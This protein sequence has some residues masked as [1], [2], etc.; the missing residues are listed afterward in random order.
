MA[1]GKRPA[2]FRTWKLSPA[3]PMVL[4]PMGCG[5]V[6]HR[7]NTLTEAARDFYSLW[8]LLCALNAISAC[9]MLSFLMSLSTALLPD[10][11]PG[12]EPTQGSRPDPHHQP[13][14]APPIKPNLHRRWLP[15]RTPPQPLCVPQTLPC[16][17][18]RTRWSS[19]PIGPCWAG[20]ASLWRVSAAGSSMHAR[21]VG[22]VARCVVARCGVGA[23]FRRAG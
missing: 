19:G 15:T 22:V 7:H 17:T 12:R 23:A 9:R 1:P 14:E 3:A 10:R 2:T 11:R 8:P 16:A 6:G 20:Y 13:T 4:Q 18:V 21:D 5:R